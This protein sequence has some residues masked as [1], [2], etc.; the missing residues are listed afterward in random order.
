VQR[1]DDGDAGFPGER[2]PRLQR[3]SDGFLS[4]VVGTDAEVVQQLI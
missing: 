1:S 3:V 4:V 2:S